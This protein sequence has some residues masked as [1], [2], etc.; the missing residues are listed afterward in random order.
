MGRQKTI[1]IGLII[2]SLIIFF[3]KIYIAEEKEWVNEI[4]KSKKPTFSIAEIGVKSIGLLP[5][6]DY[7]YSQPIT[8]LKPNETLFIYGAINL[9]EIATETTSPGAEQKIEKKRN[10]WAV[11]VKAENQKDSAVYY[12]KYIKKREKKY[13]SSIAKKKT[14]SSTKATTVLDSAVL[15][16]AT[17]QDKKVNNNL[18]ESQEVLKPEVTALDFFQQEAQLSE[19]VKDIIFPDQTLGEDYALMDSVSNLKKNDTFNIK[20]LASQ[21]GGIP[22]LILAEGYQS[23][24]KYKKKSSQKGAIFTATIQ[25]EVQNNT[26]EFDIHLLP[27]TTKMGQ[28]KTSQ[29]VHWVKIK[30]QW[31]EKELN[32]SYKEIRLI[33]KDGIAYYFTDRN[34]GASK[35]ANLSKKAKKKYTGFFYQW[36]AKLPAADINII[37]ADSWKNLNTSQKTPHQEEYSLE[38]DPCQQLENGAWTLPNQAELAAIF[39]DTTDDNDSFSENE[40]TFAENFHAVL[41]GMRDETGQLIEKNK[42]ARFWTADIFAED[43]GVSKQFLREAALPIR[44]IKR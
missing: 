15:A 26:Y 30:N 7:Q 10:F 34:L 33:G 29:I 1:V 40:A 5:K 41:S 42:T 28:E 3:M 35:F 11:K 31:I 8:Q 24:I 20:V 6:A 32:F 23:E 17:E 37:F 13:L 44:C 14:N 4:I 22:Q 12:V 2:L 27:D 25:D 39:S 36:N 43:A 38:L 19:I 16:L 21:K 9:Q 18:Q